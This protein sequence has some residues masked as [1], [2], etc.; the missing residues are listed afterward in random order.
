MAQSH[1]FLGGD[2]DAILQ[3]QLDHAT[4]EE[5]DCVARQV[6]RR[7]SRH[8]SLLTLEPVPF[9][10]TAFFTRAQRRLVR[11]IARLR[12]YELDATQAR[13]ALSLIRGRM[14]KPN[15]IIAASKALTFVP[16]LPD[17]L[18]GTMAYALTGTV[19]ELSDRY[20]RG[21]RTMSVAEI[22]STFDAS[23]REAWDQA[24]H[25][26]RNEIRTMF[27]NRDVRGAIRD[28]KREYRAGTIGAEEAVRRSEEILGDGD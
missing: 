6:I 16:V 7:S 1:T 19:G 28:V 8:S 3:G 4:L 21:G 22:Q 10:D 20:F 11:C 23:F 9:L 27:R 13:E 18:V 14:V 2:F 15:L 17:V 5:R 24:R 12:G 26:K 25:A